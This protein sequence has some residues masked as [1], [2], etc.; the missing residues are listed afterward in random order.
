MKNESLYNQGMRPFVFSEK[1]QKRW[2]RGCFNIS[3]SS[4]GQTI[5]IS[6]KTYDNE[7]DH[8][9]NDMGSGGD[10]YKQMSTMTFSYT[11]EHDHDMVFFSHF[12]PY[13]FSD[14][15]EHLKRI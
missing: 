14:M 3:Y 12:L 5:R 4:S 2:E 8:S 7:Y 9:F 13:T 1:A 11:F 6:S 15:E 10:K